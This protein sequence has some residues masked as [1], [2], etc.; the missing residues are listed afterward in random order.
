MDLHFD[1][2]GKIQA[3]NAHDGLGVDGI[4]AGDQIHVKI[5]LG[6]DIHEELDIVDGV[7]NDV[8]CFHDNYLLKFLIYI[9]QFLANITIPNL[10]SFVN[11]QL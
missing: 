5:I 9:V 8:G 3:E 7:Q 1:G 4:S 10:S 11:C 2:L 6:D